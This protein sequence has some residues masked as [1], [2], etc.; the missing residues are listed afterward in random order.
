MANMVYSSKF[1]LDCKYTNFTKHKKYF[2]NNF[3]L[4]FSMLDISGL[5]LNLFQQKLIT[6]I[7]IACHIY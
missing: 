4:F 2:F 3:C 6:N 5:L 7:F 1:D